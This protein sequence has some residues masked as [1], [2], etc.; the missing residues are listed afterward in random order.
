MVLVKGGRERDMICLAHCSPVLI[1]IVI[2]DQLKSNDI[3]VDAGGKKLKP[4]FS[5]CPRCVGSR[6]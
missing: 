6:G 5:G 3:K 4:F 2:A 1:N